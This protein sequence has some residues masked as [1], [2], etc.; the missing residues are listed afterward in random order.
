MWNGERHR[1]LRSTDDIEA[2]TFRELIADAHREAERDWLARVAFPAVYCIH[3]RGAA[4]NGDT[5]QEQDKVVRDHGLRSSEH[6]DGTDSD[7]ST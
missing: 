5:E 6:Y 1:A 3:R 7:E 2:E 4:R